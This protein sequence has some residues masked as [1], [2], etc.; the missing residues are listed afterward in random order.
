[1][2]PNTLLAIGKIV[3]VHGLR[4]NLKVYSYAESVET[5]RA[6]SQLFIKNSSGAKLCLQIIEIKPHKRQLLL[7]VEGVNTREQAQ[8][9]TGRQIFIDPANLPEL[10]P[11]VYYWTDLI[12][13]AVFTITEAYLGQIESILQT[14]A[15]DVYVVKNDH[16]QPVKETLIPALESVVRSIDLNQQTMRVALPEG[17]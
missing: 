8:V 11:G 4:G 1:M 12:G 13:L 15:N 14:G 7:T 6:A 5:Y 3:G 2:A 17:L 16:C 9:L 10:E